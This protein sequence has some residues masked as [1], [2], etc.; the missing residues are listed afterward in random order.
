M[1]AREWLEQ[2]L[3]IMSQ[4]EA[5][6]LLISVQA[7]PTLKMAGKLTALGDQRLSVEQV[8]ELV[9]AALP[10]GFKERFHRER[11]A[12]FALSLSARALSRQRLPAAQPDG[13]GDPPHRL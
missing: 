3:G 12:N 2:L 6:D 4:K 5:S 10:E 1:T 9:Y 7:P 11:E 13:H 8:R